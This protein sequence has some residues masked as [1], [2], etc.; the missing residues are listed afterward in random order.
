MKIKLKFWWQLEKK[1]KK[2]DSQKHLPNVKA[3]H[4]PEENGTLCHK[5]VETPGISIYHIDLMDFFVFGK[6]VI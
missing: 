4:F 3:K 2:S 1:K 5:G 6:I